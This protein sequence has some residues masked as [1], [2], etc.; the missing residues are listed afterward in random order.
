MTMQQSMSVV[1]SLGSFGINSCISTP[2]ALL[3]RFEKSATK[4]FEELLV[5]KVESGYVAE[6][7]FLIVVIV[8]K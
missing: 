6:I 8:K 5:P 1:A 7:L 3:V 2:L 4:I